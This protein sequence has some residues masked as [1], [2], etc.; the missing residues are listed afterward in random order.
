MGF[1]LWDPPLDRSQIQDQIL[2]EQAAKGG[3][4]SKADWLTVEIRRMVNENP[5]VSENALRKQLS[6]LP[7]VE[8]LCDSDM[9]VSPTLATRIRFMSHGRLKEI[10]CSGLKDRLS[11]A[12]KDSR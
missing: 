10:P 4:A 5:E 3:Q 6:K 8:F 12:K 2:S 9:Q 1:N 11:R 7:E